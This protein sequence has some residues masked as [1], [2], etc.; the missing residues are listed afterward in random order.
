MKRPRFICYRDFTIYLC[1]LS[2][3]LISK[4]R[5]MK[6][7]RNHAFVSNANEQIRLFDNPVLEALTR[8]HVMIPITLFLLYAAGCL[9]YTVEYTTISTRATIGMFILGWIFF[10]FIEYWI[11]KGIFHMAPTTKRKEDLA[12]KF[13]GIHHDYPKDKQRLAMPP[14]MSITVSTLILCIFYFFLNNYAFSFVAGFVV[15]YASYLSV[16]YCIHI[17][18]PPSNFLKYLWINH[19]IHHYQ[20]QDAAFG[21]SSPFWDYVFGTV[22]KTKKQSNVNVGG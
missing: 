8:T 1:F 9:Y 7:T 21:V 14:I 4:Y 5:I 6:K 2:V 13:H 17:Y 18:R 15:G 10:T 11:H 19:S 22:P 12:Y 3:K 16:H 20:D